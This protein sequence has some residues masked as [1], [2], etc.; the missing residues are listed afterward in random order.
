M[1]TSTLLDR[2]HCIHLSRIDLVAGVT[3]LM[4]TGYTKR[5]TGKRVFP[6]PPA[7]VC[8]VDR[9]PCEVVD[10]LAAKLS[11][12]PT[13]GPLCGTGQP[14]S[15]SLRAPEACLE[16]DVRGELATLVEY[17]PCDRCRGLERSVARLG[18]LGH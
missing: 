13:F 18:R 11:C 17:L 12:L 15:G 6:D 8:P 7:H 14:A 9:R 4:V 1:C 5:C 10:A 2:E 3:S 16:S